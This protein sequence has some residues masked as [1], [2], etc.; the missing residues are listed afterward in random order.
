MITDS[1]SYKKQQIVLTNT[2]SIGKGVSRGGESRGWQASTPPVREGSRG[3]HGF[4]MVISVVLSHGDPFGGV[5]GGAK[6]R[7]DLIL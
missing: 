7:Y 1:S 4:Y 3:R 6:G 2:T 5:S